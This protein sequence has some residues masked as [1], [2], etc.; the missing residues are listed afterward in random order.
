MTLGGFWSFVDDWKIVFNERRFEL[1]LGEIFVDETW[2]LRY[3]RREEN[4]WKGSGFVKDNLSTKFLKVICVTIILNKWK[5]SGFVEDKLSTKPSNVTCIM[6]IMCNYGTLG[7]RWFFMA[8][9]G[10]HCLLKN[11][12]AV[13]RIIRMLKSNSIRSLDRMTKKR[14]FELCRW[15]KK[16]ENWNSSIRQQRNESS[17]FINAT[18]KWKFELYRYDYK[19]MKV[20]SLSIQ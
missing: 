5:G 11:T 18:K 10:R 20:W 2:Q 8:V 9:S 13:M 1:Y 15:N 14:K 12:S 6:I 3:N 7:V 17:S 4:K 19:K 16:M